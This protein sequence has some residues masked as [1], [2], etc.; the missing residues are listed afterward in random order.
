[1]KFLRSIALLLVALAAAVPVLAQAP[2][3]RVQGTIVD[4]TG[5]A[6]PGVSVT[7][8][9]DETGIAVTRQSGG[10]GR[11]LFDQVD[12]GTYTLTA[13]RPGFNTLVQK[14]VPVH[15]RGDV[16]ADITLKVSDVVETVT[17]E[18]SPVGVQFNTTNQ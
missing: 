15:Q 10:N 6:V 3:G 7:L 11:Y 9:N 1:M 14:N 16:T 4:T 2:R 18:A 12:P 8:Q 13:K 17:V 5:G